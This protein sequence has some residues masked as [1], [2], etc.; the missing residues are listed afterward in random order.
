MG[1]LFLLCIAQLMWPPH[2]AGLLVRREVWE[3]G[4]GGWTMLGLPDIFWVKS[5]QIDSARKLFY[6]GLRGPY[7]GGKCPA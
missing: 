5:Y 4:M 3:G 7:S 2:Q 1:S 6:V